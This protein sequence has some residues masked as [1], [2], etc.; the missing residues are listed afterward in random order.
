MRVS[1]LLRQSLEVFQAS[2]ARSF[3]TMLGITFGVGCLIAVAVVGLAFRGSV[4]SEMGRYGSTLVWVQPNWAAYADNEARIPMDGRDVEY[5]RTA[6]PGL[7][8]SS[9]IFQVTDAV[10]YRGESVRTSVLGVQPGHFDMFSVAVAR[11]RA[12]LPQEVELKRPVC[13]L[14]PDIAARLFHDEDPLHRVVRIGERGYTV[15]GITERLEQGILGDG[16]DN[17]SVFVPEDLMGA[18]VWGGGEPRY[19]VYVMKFDAVERLDAAVERIE[20]WLSNRYGTLRGEKRFQAS[21]LDSFLKIA[22][23]VLNTVSVLVLT[24]AAISL[25]VG[26]LGITNIMLVTVT[27]RTREIGVRMAVGASRRDVVSQFVVEAVVFCLAGG[28]AGVLFG[29]GLAAVACAVLQWK[30]AVPLAIVLGALGVSTAIGLLFGIY[31]AWKAS[32]LTPVEAL[33]A[34]T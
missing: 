16:S 24:V 5:F 30:I 2:K 20:N 8:E 21:R 31:P 10:S 12:F 14:R 27:E 32:R 25:V 22:E 3:L 17:N 11:G 7:V 26:G 34:E 19:W 33:R 29:T 28:A 18:R 6:L 23:N 4:G 13:V 9:S 1:E 15:V